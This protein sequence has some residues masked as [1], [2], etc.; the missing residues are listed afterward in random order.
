MLKLGFS[1]TYCSG[2]QMT[3][4]SKEMATQKRLLRRFILAQQ[5]NRR[6]YCTGS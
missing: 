2:S 3:A 1:K 5:K 6:M 4:N